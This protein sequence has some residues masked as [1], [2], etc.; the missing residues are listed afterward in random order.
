[1]VAVSDVAS[2]ELPVA[3]LAGA[4]RSLRAQLTDAMAEGADEEVRFTL[5]AIEVEFEVAITREVGGDASVHFWVL[6]AEAKAASTTAATH[7]LKLQLKPGRR[8]PETG[9]L[10]ELELGDVVNGR[11]A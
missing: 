1:V 8:N 9:D 7:R 4:L 5:E 10:S 3:D 11:P 2:T 6:T